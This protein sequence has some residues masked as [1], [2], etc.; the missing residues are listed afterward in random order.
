MHRRRSAEPCAADRP[1]EWRPEPT[2]PAPHDDHDRDAWRASRSLSHRNASPLLASL[3][4]WLASRG[5]RRGARTARTGIG[6]VLGGPRASTR[7][8]AENWRSARTRSCRSRSIAPQVWD[9]AYRGP[10][11]TLPTSARDARACGGRGHV[12]KAAGGAA[13]TD[14]LIGPPPLSSMSFRVVRRAA[15]VSASRIVAGEGR[16]VAGE[17]EQ[18]QHRPAW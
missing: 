10:R 7:P 12:G 4:R 17:I 13:P 2:R 14:L 6:Q 16:A 11:S 15:A 1:A 3:M 18:S 5:R 9:R 8:G